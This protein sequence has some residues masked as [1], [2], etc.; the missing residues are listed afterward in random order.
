MAE[1]RYRIEPLASAHKRDGFTC[2][3][4]PLDRYLKAQ[5]S[6]DVRRR[7]SSCFV[8]VDTANGEIAGYYTLAATGI[9]LDRLPDEIVR[10]LPR[11]PVVPA[12]L[13]GRLAI[14]QTQQKQG[15][16][17]ALIADAFKRVGAADVMAFALIVDAKDDGA[18]RFYVHFGFRLL[19]GEMSRL[20]LPVA[21]ALKLL[22]PKS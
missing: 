12:A 19:A 6:Q 2:G 20:A 5:A 14:A 11:Y 9:P 4:E 7:V 10:K 21:T 22:D 3:V 16:G 1:P 13:L 17:K 15:L 18:K 8:A